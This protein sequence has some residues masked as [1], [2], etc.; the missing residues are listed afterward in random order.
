M[1]YLLFLQTI[2]EASA[3]V[4]DSFML[5]LSSLGESMITYLLLAFIYWCFD[6]RIE[7]LMGF[8]IS[9]AGW[10]TLGFE[11]WR[12]SD[13]LK[14]VIAYLLMGIVALIMFSRNYLGVHTFGDVIVSLFIGIAIMFAS[15]KL[16]TWVDAGDK[17]THKKIIG[18]DGIIVVIS[19]VLSLI[20][21]LRY[22][23]LS[24]II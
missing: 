17:D 21:M 22:G 16:L 14:R 9:F 15:S 13:K 11:L 20:P 1:S 19:C 7:Q 10:G 12:T 3:G 18:R 4:L 6:K 8:N 2:R 5:Q 23:C 24:N